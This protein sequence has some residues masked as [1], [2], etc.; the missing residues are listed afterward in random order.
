MTLIESF[1]SISGRNDN[2]SQSQCSGLPDIRNDFK[3]KMKCILVK[4]NRPEARKSKKK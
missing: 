4:A 1:R 2:I 3:L